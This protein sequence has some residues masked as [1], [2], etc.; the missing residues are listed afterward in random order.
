M[1][2]TTVKL[3]DD[4][5]QRLKRF[6]EENGSSVSWILRK[7]AERWLEEREANSKPARRKEAVK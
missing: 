4:L 6:S 2:I 3:P 7:A 1:H 5:K